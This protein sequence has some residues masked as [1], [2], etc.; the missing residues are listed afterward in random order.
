MKTEDLKPGRVYMIKGGFLLRL[1]FVHGLPC[2][3]RFRHPVFSSITSDFSSIY[4]LASS[5]LREITPADLPWIHTRRA[6][7][8]ARSLPGEVADMDHLIE[9]LSKET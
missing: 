8:A 3:S 7:A 2:F 6:Q 4:I 5:I 9:E 1:Q